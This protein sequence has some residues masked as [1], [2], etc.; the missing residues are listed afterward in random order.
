MMTAGS[1]PA[2]REKAPFF[3]RF[4]RIIWKIIN[5]RAEIVKMGAGVFPGE[6]FP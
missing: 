1:N 5:G 6:T 2:G 3:G 4:V